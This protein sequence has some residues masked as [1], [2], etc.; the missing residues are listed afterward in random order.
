MLL[1]CIIKVTVVGGGEILVLLEVLLLLLPL[2][3]DAFDGLFCILM[4]STVACIGAPDDIHAILLSQPRVR[5]ATQIATKLTMAG[6]AAGLVGPLIPAFVF[7]DDL[8]SLAGIN[9]GRECLTST[10]SLTGD[11]PDVGV[12]CLGTNGG[13]EHFLEDLALVSGRAR[14]RLAV[15]GEVGT[16]ARKK[17]RIKAIHKGWANTDRKLLLVDE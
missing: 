11:C 7:T 5:S 17:A 1:V 2:I 9:L 6:C 3:V 15:V 10:N 4:K 8:L 16:K 13:L 14:L 12:L